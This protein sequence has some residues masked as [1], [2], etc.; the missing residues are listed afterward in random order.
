VD[1]FRNS[2]E[3]QKIGEMFKKLTD[4]DLY[5]SVKI[6]SIPTGHTDVDRIYR[7]IGN[8]QNHIVKI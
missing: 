7:I 2:T 6:E 5:V 8:Y 4:N 3:F 1:F